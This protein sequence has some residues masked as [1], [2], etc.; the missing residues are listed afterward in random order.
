MEAAPSLNLVGWLMTWGNHVLSY[1]K[2][3]EEKNKLLA[4]FSLNL[5]RVWDV[6]LMALDAPN[7]K[8]IVLPQK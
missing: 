3:K 4:T 8:A 5:V 2:W 7:D 6:E 1:L